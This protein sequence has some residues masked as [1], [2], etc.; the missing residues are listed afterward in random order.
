LYDNSAP[1]PWSIGQGNI[2]GNSGVVFSI[3]NSGQVQYTSNDIGATGYS[4][5]LTFRGL[6]IQI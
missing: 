6:S 2:L 5:L 4:G 1:T 3:T